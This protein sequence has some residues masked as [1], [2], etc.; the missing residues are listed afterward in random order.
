MISKGIFLYHTFYKPIH[1]SACSP[2]DQ[3]IL[4]QIIHYF[5]TEGG[6]DYPLSTILQSLGIPLSSLYSIYSI[7]QQLPRGS[8]PRRVASGTPRLTSNVLCQSE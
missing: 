5:I 3:A 1:L 4:S 8:A 2:H 6:T 7:I